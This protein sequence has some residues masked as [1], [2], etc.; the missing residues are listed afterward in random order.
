MFTADARLGASLA[1]SITRICSGG[2]RA[3]LAAPHTRIASAVGSGQSITSG[4]TSN[5]A[6]STASDSI[7]VRSIERSAALPPHTLPK[8]RPTPN[9]TSMAVTKVVDAAASLCRIGAM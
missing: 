2:T 4:N 1:A 6:I 5:T 3:K 7:R 9:N 8:V